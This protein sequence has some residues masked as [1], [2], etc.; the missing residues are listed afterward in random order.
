MDF[1]SYHTDRFSSHYDNFQNKPLKSN[2]FK[3]L[4]KV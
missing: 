3:E 1:E 4:R 2:Y